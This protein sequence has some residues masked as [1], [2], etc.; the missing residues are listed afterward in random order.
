LILNGYNVQLGSFSAICNSRSG[1]DSI[2]IEFDI[3]FDNSSSSNAQRPADERGNGTSRKPIPLALSCTVDFSQ[4]FGKGKNTAESS[5]VRVTNGNYRVTSSEP[6]QRLVNLEHSGG[7]EEYSSPINNVEMTVRSSTPDEDARLFERTVPDYQWLALSESSHNFLVA[8]E[9]KDSTADPHAMYIAVISHFLPKYIMQSFSV[10]RRQREESTSTLELLMFFSPTANIFQE[11][12]ALTEPISNFLDASVSESLVQKM[13]AILNELEDAPAVEGD[14][15]RALLQDIHDKLELAGRLSSS[16]P[17]IERIAGVIS[18]SLFSDPDS[19]D[20]TVGFD[21]MYCDSVAE[22][23]TLAADRTTDYFV[24]NIRYL[25]PL[26]LEPD[27]A[28]SFSPSSEPNDVGPKGEYAAVVFDAHRHRTISWWNPYTATVD[29]GPFG[30]A[31][32][33]WLQYIGVAEAVSVQEAAISGYSWRVRPAHDRVQRPLSAVGVGV[34]QVLPILIAGLLAPENALLLIEQ[35]ELHLHPRAQARL[36]D[37]F[38]GLALTSRRCIVETHSEPFINQLR[39]NLVR[40]NIIADD[41]V[42]IYFA[43]QDEYADSTFAP[44]EV[45]EDGVIV[46]W[47]VGFFDENLLLEDKITEAAIRRRVQAR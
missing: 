21:M 41:V 35:P 37:F 7:V 31:V 47:P 13:N 16:S 24:R 42:R 3:D 26:R 33:D 23:I 34:S 18:E 14:S 10:V 2:R 43:T 39:W 38:V 8:F 6:L 1:S 45:N 11:R 27:A 4:Q 40:G 25:G 17:E 9:P 22:A 30:R 12:P 20:D 5:R 29:T 36:T 44:I 28:Q 15:L 19:D 46:N 32:N